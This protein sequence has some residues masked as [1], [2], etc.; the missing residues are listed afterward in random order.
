MRELAEL[1]IDPHEAAQEPVVK[2]EVDVEVIADDHQTYLQADETEA[3]TWLEEE[4]LEAV[5]DR[6]LDAE[7]VERRILSQVEERD[8]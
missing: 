8:P 7:F 1:E 5:Y 6:L 2:D 3:F 4:G